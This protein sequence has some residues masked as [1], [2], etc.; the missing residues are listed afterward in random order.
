MINK[1]NLSLIT[2][3][4]L[5]N[6]I[7]KYKEGRDKEIKEKK[8]LFRNK[9]FIDSEEEKKNNYILLKAMLRKDKKAIQTILD[10][11]KEKKKVNKSTCADNHSLRKY[12]N[13]SV[14]L[15]FPLENNISSEKMLIDKKFF[16]LKKTKK[17]IWK[18]EIFEKFA[19]NRNKKFEY[20]IKNAFSISIGGKMPPHLSL[21][22]IC[23]KVNQD[24]S[25]SFINFNSSKLGEISLF[26]IF[27]GNGPY[28]KQISSIVK[29]YI[30]NYFKNCDDMRVTLKKDNFYSI[31]YNAFTNAQNYLINNNLKLNI[32]MDFSGVTGCILLYPHNSTNKIYCANLGRNKCILYTMFGDIRLS[33][34]LYPKRPSEKYRI[35]LLK[36]NKDKIEIHCDNNDIIKILI[37]DENNTKNTNIT[38][39]FTTTNNF[40]NNTNEINKDNEINTNKRNEEK[41]INEL[42]LKEFF[43]LDISR[44]IGNLKA[45]EFG[46]IPGPEV[47]ENDI[48]INRGKYIVMGTWPLWKYLSEFEVGEIVNKYLATQDS[49]NACKEL[50]FVAKERWK[51]DTG[52]FNDMSV[53]VIFFDLKNINV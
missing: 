37:N 46:I 17:E 28:G 49:L 27:D 30:I 23:T 41:N 48:R 26:G 31:M 5:K 11:E 2:N 8:L 3:N 25:F 33:Y 9:S 19:K 21:N 13:K 29:D 50:E 24:T 36:K 43:E 42:Y 35:S 44:C 47:I 22:N 40:N 20:K 16:I 7:T 34:E 10:K 51:S 1:N 39:T 18:N 52:G 15:L 4:T 14:P 32:N 6:I 53:I 12:R 38:N 45:E